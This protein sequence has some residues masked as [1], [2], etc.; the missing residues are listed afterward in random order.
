MEEYAVYLRKSRADIELEAVTK[1]DT[2]RRHKTLLQDLAKNR[3]LKIV[4]YYEEVVSGE[5]IADRPEMQRLLRDI[6]QNK[7]TGVLVVEIER[8][9]RGDTKDQGIVADAFKYTDTL[10]ITPTKTYD[11]NNEF[12][13]EYFE[14][15][16]FMSRREYKTIHRR[17][18]RGKIDSVKEGNYIASKRPYGYD[19]IRPTKKERTL[20]IRENEAVWVKRMYQMFAEDKLSTHAIA[21]EFTIMGAPTYSGKT[22]W[23]HSMINEMLRNP[24]YMGYVRWRYR[25]E[26]KSFD[27]NGNVK[28]LRK[29]QKDNDKIVLAK[30]KHQPIITEELF[31][32]A[33]RRFEEEPQ[34]VK[35]ST[36]LINPFA[37]LVHCKLCGMNFFYHD[38]KKSKGTRIRMTHKSAVSCKVKSCFYDD[39]LESVI[40][41][42]QVHLDNFELK[43]N[44][45]DITSHLIQHEEMI[46]S[47][48]KE[49][50]S[51][52]I[53]RA[54]L[55]DFLERNIYTEDEFIERKIILD[56][57]KKKL[58]EQL[59]KLKDTKPEPVDYQEKV[60]NFSQAI[61]ALK[62]D[63]V[64]AR[65]K[66][67]LL[68][69]I[70]KDIL[71]YRIDDD[72]F[73]L[74]IILH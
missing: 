42:L 54:S 63:N 36:E 3:S 47:L 7:Y 19:I 18:E 70:I 40:E 24:L 2:L 38:N 37:G 62:D 4:E 17:M 61:N 71:Y 55:F 64:S 11:P 43:L 9:A 34:R 69:V 44:N 21:R 14:F 48:E 72:T 22:E 53:R 35:L 59:Q 32:A 6:Y 26:T 50:Q 10:I 73:G 49:L 16:L 25:P 56:D 12:D 13:E 5:T 1:E 58:E 33:Q 41:I 27:E 8:L 68:K 46:S 66:N 45:S 67:N 31:G 29:R 74:D 15:G 28:I 30:G 65:E 23:S 39:F 51:I 57:Q 20:T 52:N 60:Y